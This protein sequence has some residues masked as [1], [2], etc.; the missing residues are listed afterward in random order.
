MLPLQHAPQWRIASILLMAAILTAT[1]IP[2]AWFFG[3]KASALSW[4]AHVDKWLHGVTFLALA[5]W[6][7][8]QYRMRSYWRIAAGL[9]IFGFFIELCQLM[10]SYRTADWIDIGANTAGIIV[11]LAAALTGLGGW[12]LRVEAWHTARSTGS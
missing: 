10:I 8:G 5:L 2:A 9:M 3:D 1:L 7:A 4:F 12:C 6:F 11:G